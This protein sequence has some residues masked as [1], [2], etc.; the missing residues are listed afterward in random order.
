MRSQKQ[1]AKPISGTAVNPVVLFGIDETGKPRAAKFS[2]KLADLAVKAAGQ[3]DL[4]VLTINNQ[5]LA[6]LAAQLPEGRIHATGRGFIPFIRKGLFEKLIEAAGTG[7]AVGSSG[8]GNGTSGAN[9]P[10]TPG[11]PSGQPPRLFPLNWDDIS[12]GQ[13]VLALEDPGEGWYEANV[14]DRRGDTLGLKY[15]DYAT[16]RRFTE[17]RLSV[18]LICPSDP[19]ESKASKPKGH[20]LVGSNAEPFPKTWAEIGVNSLVLAKDDGP[21]RSWWEAIP[22][23]QTDDAFT[24]RWRDFPQV[25]NVVRPRRALA[26]LYPNQ[27]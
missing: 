13:V 14:I 2:D 16:A 6:D 7:T 11:T 26:L 17:H 18:A 27:K 3:L 5:R 8:G 23:D 9:G 12:P 4:K 19:D 21:W 10:G 20:G 22:V 25:P 15:R 1:N 24:L